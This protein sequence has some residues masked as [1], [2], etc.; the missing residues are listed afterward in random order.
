MLRTLATI[1][2]TVAS[3]A[4]V[5]AQDA[6][7]FFAKARGHRTSFRYEFSATDS[8]MRGGGEAT[9]QDGAF[10]VSGGGLEILCDG[11]TRW[12]VD[13]EGREV[14][15]EGVGEDEA[16]R[17]TMNPALLISDFDRAFVRTG[18]KSGLFHGRQAR[19]V[20]YV[21]SVSCDVA[22]VKMYFA[23]GGPIGA[24]LTASDGTVMEFGFSGWT[25]NEKAEDLSAFRLDVQ[26]LSSDY[27]VT[28]LR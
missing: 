25:F 26:N 2:L 19:A 14:L 6:G 7:A 8:G 3:C 1:L 18:E 5:S 24:E 27:I 22:G 23:G 11:T 12:T 20:S 4:A 15:I 16:T 17:Y 13:R 9:V 10:H 21:P 28:D